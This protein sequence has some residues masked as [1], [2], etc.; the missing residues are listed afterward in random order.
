MLFGLL[1][2][3]LFTFETPRIA[4]VREGLDRTLSGFQ[5]DLAS[6]IMS[7]ALFKSGYELAAPQHRLT[8][9]A[10]VM[11]VRAYLRDLERVRG[12]DARIDAMFTDPG[13]Q[14]PQS[15][16]RELREARETQRA[17]LAPRQRVAEA[18][19]QEQIEAVLRE[20]G[21]AIGG[22]TWPPVRFEMTQL[23]HL[24][25][26]SRRD[27]IEKI[28]QR[29]LT[30]GLKADDFDAIE[31]HTE[32]RFDVSALVTPIGGYGAYPTMLP[33]TP[34]L[35]FIVNT[36]AHEWTHIYLLASPV[37][38]NYGN[39]GAARTINETS[40]QIVE[41][42]IGRRVLER[43]YPREAAESAQA[44]GLTTDV[45]PVSANQQTFDFNAEM[46]E[47]RLRVD[48][49]LKAGRIEEAERY[50]EA[51]RVLFVDN[52]YLIRRLN[53]AYF[54]FYGAYNA[55]PGGAP[56][57]GRDP[58]GPAVRALRA[59]ASSLGAFVR[60]IAGVR[61]LADVEAALR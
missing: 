18:I 29:E 48:D 46:R 45:S 20:E 54:A 52:G 14:D 24:L 28:D 32:R 34:S 7:S 33:E 44:A 4:N 51:R 40:A 41:R 50:M 16:S 37:G 10:Q 43:F 60:A 2:M 49:L 13:V 56:E 58:I 27:R 57:A 3:T 39:D 42:E 22:Q 19:L 11:F 30:T 23:P 21:F 61:T 5:F 53:Q 9:A 6:W 35:N 15:A 47:T 59:R 8:D 36:A 12:L 25:V 38:L 26:I 17:N 1:L 55:R 31:R